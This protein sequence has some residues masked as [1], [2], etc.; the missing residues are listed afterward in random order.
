MVQTIEVL[1]AYEPY[2]LV[3]KGAVT[4]TFTRAELEAGLGCPCHTATVTATM[5]GETHTYTGLPLWRLGAYVD[6]DR[7]PTPEQGIHYDDVDFNDALAQ[8]GYK[9]TLLAQDGYSQSVSSTL[10]THGDHF[11]VAFKRDGVFLDP[12]TD[13]YMRFVYDDS[14]VLPQGTSLKSVKFLAEIRIGS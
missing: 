1:G 7:F 13:G 3:L 4:R 14:V 6:D 9:I 10:I 8:A 5:K 11:I 12:A 2:S